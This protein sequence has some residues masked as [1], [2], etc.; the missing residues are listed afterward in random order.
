M[1]SPVLDE[2][3]A[4]SGSTIDAAVLEHQP[5]PG[6]QRPPAGR[7]ILPQDRDRPAVA[8]AI[9]LDDLHGRGLA[10][11]VRPEQG[12]DLTATDRQ[13]HAVEH[14]PRPVPL[15]HAIEDD[16]RLA[17]RRD[18]GAMRAYWRSK[19]ASLAWPIWMD[20]RTPCPS[21]K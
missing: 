4:R 11:A 1:E 13:G 15:D 19:S 18:H 2:R 9:A 5:D 12:H 6:S 16:R 17:G 3:L 8:R 10:G 20:R 14:G 7:G 21:M